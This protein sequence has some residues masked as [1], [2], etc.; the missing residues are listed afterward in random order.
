MLPEPI[1]DWKGKTLG[2]GLTYR[3]RAIII[4][5]REKIAK[6]T[7]RRPS[8]QNASRVAQQAEKVEQVEKGRT[9]EL[10]NH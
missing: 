8:H 3:I 4:L 9:D 2:Y 6:T 7:E 5:F 1:S 10:R